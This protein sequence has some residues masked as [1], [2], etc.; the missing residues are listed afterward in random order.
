VNRPAIELQD[1]RVERS[2]QTVLDIVRLAFEPAMVHAIVGD[3][4]AGKSTLLMAVGGLLDLAHGRVLL[5][6]QPFHTGRAPAPRNLRRNLACV[7]QEP[8][9]FAGTVARNVGLGLRIRKQSRKQTAALV[10][11][12]LEQLGIADLAQRPARELS[13][14]ERKLVALAQALVLQ[15]RVLLLDEVSASLDDA[16]IE[17]VRGQIAQLVG[18]C[19]TCVVWVTHTPD[20][21]RDLVNTTV[22]LR[23][24]RSVSSGSQSEVSNR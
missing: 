19:G 21:A 24:G 22:R 2:G 4:G 9:L 11:Q 1:V 10:G 3:N 15:P 13:G 20:V 23:A 5:N 17:R 7:F 16:A 14:G 8:Y 12:T 18:R 6:G